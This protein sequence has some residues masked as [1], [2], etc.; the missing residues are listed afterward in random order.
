METNKVY[1]GDSLEVLK[2]NRRFVGIELNPEY[3]KII[4]E[5][6]KPYVEQKKFSDVN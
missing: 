3:I 2:N 1:C 5:R 6:I 4:S